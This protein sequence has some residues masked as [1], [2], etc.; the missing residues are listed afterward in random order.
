MSIHGWLR[1]EETPTAAKLQRLWAHCVQNNFIREVGGWPTTTVEWRL[2]RYGAGA[3]GQNRNAKD[4]TSTEASIDRLKRS[5]D[6]GLWVHSQLYSMG[7][8]RFGIAYFSYVEDLDAESIGAIIEQDPKVVL[9][10][11]L[12]T[13]RHLNRAVK[14]AAKE[15]GIEEVV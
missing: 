3:V 10:H 9:G 14:H 5:L 1:A 12:L 2:K 11:R 8:L 4:L 15:A 6:V 13:A 7:E